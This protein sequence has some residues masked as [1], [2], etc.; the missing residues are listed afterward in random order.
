LLRYAPKASANGYGPPL[1]T[2]NS[3]LKL[4]GLK[5]WLTTN[6]ENRGDYIGKWLAIQYRGGDVAYQPASLC[7]NDMSVRVGRVA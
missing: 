6:A 3:R 4:L 5:F 7:K 1:K 2:S